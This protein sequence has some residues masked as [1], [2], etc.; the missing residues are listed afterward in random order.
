[1]PNIVTPQNRKLKQHV[2]TLYVTQFME[3]PCL[4]LGRRLHLWVQTLYVTHFYGHTMFGKHNFAQFR[5]VNSCK[6]LYLHK[7]AFSLW[8]ISRVIVQQLRDTNQ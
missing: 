2:Q 6:T 3:I 7:M 5:T 4:V 1:M 8:I